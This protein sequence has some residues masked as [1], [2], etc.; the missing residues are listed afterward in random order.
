MNRPRHHFFS[1]A[2]LADDEHTEIRLCDLL[3]RGNH[4]ADCLART[5]TLT[6]R[7]HLVNV[8]GQ[9]LQLHLEAPLIQSPKHDTSDLLM[10]KWLGNIVVRPRADCLYRSEDFGKPRNQDHRQIG[11][12]FLRLAHQLHAVHARH[13]EVGKHDIR[14]CGTYQLQ[15]LDT[16]LCQ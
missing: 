12:E 16:I 8:I 4:L 6:R 5:K 14:V 10:L 1:G 2:G 3:D 13:A 15:C 9:V 7:E 11:V